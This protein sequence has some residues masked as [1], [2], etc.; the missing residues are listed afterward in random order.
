MKHPFPSKEGSMDRARLVAIARELFQQH[1]LDARGWRLEFRNYA[2]RLGTCCSRRRIIALNAF[3]ADKN[4]E[5][6]VV[7]TLLHEIAHVL[8][9]P[10]HG[11]GPVWKAMAQKLGCIP[12]ACS[13]TGL[14]LRPGKWQAS[15]PSCAQQFHKYRRPKKVRYFCPSCGKERGRLVFTVQTVSQ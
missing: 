14:V 3:Y 13:K 7:D 4:A 10:A 1:G 5:A 6:V 8:V 11:H 9:G 15:C 12:K 2:H